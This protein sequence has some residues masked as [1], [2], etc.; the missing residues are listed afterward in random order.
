[1][2]GVLRYLADLVGRYD[3]RIHRRGLMRI[4]LAPALSAYE[5]A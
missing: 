2:R 4:L 1:M 3:P 5:Q